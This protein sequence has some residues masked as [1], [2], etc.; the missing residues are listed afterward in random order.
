ME[1]NTRR[2][3]PF[4]QREKH[5]SSGKVV[6]KTIASPEGRGQTPA[7]MEKNMRIARRLLGAILLTS[8][9]AT[10]LGVAAEGYVCATSGV[11]MTHEARIA[12]TH[13]APAKQAPVAQFERPC[14]VYVGGTALPPVLSA[15]SIALVSPVRAVA[16]VP[17]TVTAQASPVYLLTAPEIDADGGGGLSPPIQLVRAVQLR[18]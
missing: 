14:C 13:C 10:P 12:C 3:K 11:R 2:A 6:P 17:P 8:L 9:S 7:H 5:K 4:R 18:N 15:A 16:A 1:P